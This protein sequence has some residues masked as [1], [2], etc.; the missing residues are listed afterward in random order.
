MPKLISLISAN[1]FTLV[2]EPAE[3]EL[4]LAKAA[5]EAGADALQLMVKNNLAIE[6]PHL[7]EIVKNAK[8]PVGLVLGKDVSLEDE[9]MRQIIK[10]GFDFVSVGVQHLSPV[11]LGNKKLSRI[12]ALDS[13]FSFDEVIELS[14]TSFEVIDAAIIPVSLKGKDLA[15]GDLQN[16]I[17]IIISTGLPVI[18]PTQCKVRVSEVPILA[19]A[20]AKG[21]ILTQTIIGKTCESIKEA[22]SEFRLAID[23]L[24]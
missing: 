17:S 1:K 7:A 2:V 13:R 10:Q 9:D 4:E 16:Y 20:G 11:V 19:D 6:L 8:I 22:V 15:V 5:Q 12:L 23:E 21:I 18:I 14:K 24:N 3:N